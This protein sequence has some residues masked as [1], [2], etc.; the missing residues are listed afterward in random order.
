M[1]PA[2]KSEW[3]KRK[4]NWLKNSTSRHIYLIAQGIMGFH[5]SYSLTN[6]LFSKE[7]MQS[8]KSKPNVIQIIF[9][10]HLMLFHERTISVK[11]ARL[12]NQKKRINLRRRDVSQ[13]HEFKRIAWKNIEGFEHKKQN[14]IFSGLK[15]SGMCNYSHFLLHSRQCISIYGYKRQHLYWFCKESDYE[16]ALLSVHQV[17]VHVCKL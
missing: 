10:S 13:S 15:N 8:T 3:K 9:Q 12:L 4:F 5:W 11:I 7:F 17:P 16:D 6:Q 1:K 14:I 2:S